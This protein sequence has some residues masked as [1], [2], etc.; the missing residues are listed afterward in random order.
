[1]SG[2]QEHLLIHLGPAV[3][4]T[5]D[6]LL[7]NTLSDYEMGVHTLVPSLNQAGH[8]DIQ[9]SMAQEATLAKPPDKH[10][11][12]SVPMST[13]PTIASIR[14]TATSGGLS[15]KRLLSRPFR[16]PSSTSVITHVWDFCNDLLAH[17]TSGKGTKWSGSVGMALRSKSFPVTISAQ[18]D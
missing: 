9:P 7:F 18:S 3:R 4:Y 15:A 10:H 12:P 1:M 17:A 14:P 2:L 13:T 11:S 16:R 8:R 5:P 6:R